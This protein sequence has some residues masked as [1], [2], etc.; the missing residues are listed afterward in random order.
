MDR[1]IA[2]HVCFIN[3]GHFLVVFCKTPKVHDHEKGNYGGK[4]FK[5]LFR[6]QSFPHMY[7]PEVQV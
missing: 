4:L 7:F 1:T 3:F 2:Q 6:T 5:F